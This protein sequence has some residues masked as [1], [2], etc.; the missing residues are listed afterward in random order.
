MIISLLFYHLEYKNPDILQW[1]ADN[2]KIQLRVYI[3][4]YFAHVLL[5]NKCHS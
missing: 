4:M 3:S 1:K 2:Y 5:K